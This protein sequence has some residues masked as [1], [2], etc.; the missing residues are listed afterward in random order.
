MRQRLDPD[1]LLKL[2]D[3]G[4]AAESLLAV[5]EEGIRTTDR[6]PTGVSEGKRGIELIA[7]VDHGIENG[8]PLR[9]GDVEGVEPR[10]LFGLNLRIIA[11]DLDLPGVLVGL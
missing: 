1:R 11:E 3:L 4:L 5:D 6:L 10:L 8:H 9:E 2:G 7:G